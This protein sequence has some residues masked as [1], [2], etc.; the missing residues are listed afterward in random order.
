MAR[1]WVKGTIGPA[2]RTACG[3]WPDSEHRCR[4]AHEIGPSHLNRPQRP[5]DRPCWT[6]VSFRP[7]N[8]TCRRVGQPCRPS[9]GPARRATVPAAQPNATLLNRPRVCGRKMSFICC[10]QSAKFPVT[11]NTNCADSTRIAQN[12][13]FGHL[14]RVSDLA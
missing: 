3:M 10:A 11:V 12:L 7:V 9:V 8:S 14:P 2:A 13:V 6:R 1:Y 4:V 5:V